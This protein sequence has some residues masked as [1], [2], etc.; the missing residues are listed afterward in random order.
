LAYALDRQLQADDRGALLLEGPDLVR[1]RDAEGNQ[2]PVELRDLSLLLLQRCLR[3]LE[4]SMLPLERRPGI[5]E[6]GPLL[7]ELTLGLLAGSMLLPELLL[8]CDNRGDLSGEGGLQFFGFLGL[9]LSLPRPLLGLASPGPLLFELHTDL[10]VLSLD[11]DH[12]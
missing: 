6:G 8:R 10:P 2:L 4:S 11:G 9:L 3:S 5:N 1:V 7:L 12:L